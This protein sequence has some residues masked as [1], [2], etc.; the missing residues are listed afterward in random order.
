MPD[1]T[2]VEELEAK[3]HP[4]G[5]DRATISKLRETLVKKSREYPKMFLMYDGDSEEGQTWCAAI[6]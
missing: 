6:C 4:N 1:Y 2:S 3:V 5:M